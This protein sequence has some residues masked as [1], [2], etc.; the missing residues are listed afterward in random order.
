MNAALIGIHKKSLLK[1]LTAMTLFAPVASYGQGAMCTSIFSSDIQA[2]Q[3]I[4]GTWRKSSSDLFMGFRSNAPHFWNWLYQNQDAAILGPRGVATGDP[5]IQNFGDVPLKQGGRKYTLIDVDDSGANASLAGDFLR[6][7]VGNQISPFKVDAK[8]L[9]KAYVDGVNGKKM[10]KPQYLKEIESN[11]D[12]DFQT[13]NNKK[14]GKLTDGDK[15]NDKA[16]LTPL[17]KTPQAIQ[18]LLTQSAPVFKSHMQ[19]MT[20][21][22]TGFKEKDT[23]GSQDLPRFWFLLADAQGN[24]HIYEFKMETAPATSLFAGQP[25]SL[26]RFKEVADTYRPK[27]EVAGPFEFIVAGQYTFL[28]RERFFSYVDL[29]PAK[30]TSDSDMNNAK[31]MSLYIANKMGEAHGK[32]AAGKALANQLGK[33]D[34]FDQLDAL[35][36]NYIALITK[37]NQ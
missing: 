24:R 6:Y 31:Q 30:I 13:H 15:F 21:L 23:G 22:D 9:F 4:D 14:I 20:Y 7:F 5:H 19:G 36:K 11:S 29:D 25:D 32:Q 2:T 12:S 1:F 16:E 33:S 35:A 34:A 3:T 10:D 18:D 26:T 27:E 28:L 8:D 37:L 17:S